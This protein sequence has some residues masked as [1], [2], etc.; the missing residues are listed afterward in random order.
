MLSQLSLQVNGGCIACPARIKAE[1][2]LGEG[3][4]HTEWGTHPIGAQRGRKAEWIQSSVTVAPWKTAIKAA[5]FHRHAMVDGWRGDRR[6]GESLVAVCHPPAHP[7]KA[8]ALES[9]GR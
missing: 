9:V 3:A 7:L 6:R 2:G 5:A 4:G 8:K 1:H